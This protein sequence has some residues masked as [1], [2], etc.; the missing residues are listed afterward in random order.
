LVPSPLTPPKTLLSSSS[1]SLAQLELTAYTSYKYVG[2]TINTVVGLALGST[3]YYAC[4]AYTGAAA[5]YFL[6]NTLN[7]LVDPS[8]Y[9]AAG[10]GASGGGGPLAGGTGA[11]SMAVRMQRTY[12]VIGAGAM[13]L[14]LMWWLG[15][16]SD[17]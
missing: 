6:I 13:Q 5:A 12:V 3:A 2:L 16:S 1:D 15:Q 9:S 11:P 4:M 7:P 17:L 14:V 10:G 8:R